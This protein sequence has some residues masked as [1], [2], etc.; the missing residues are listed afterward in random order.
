MSCNIL[1]VTLA[2]LRHTT[3]SKLAAAARADR[4]YQQ[5]AAAANTTEN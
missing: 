4:K 5:Q 2:R 3:C 1:T